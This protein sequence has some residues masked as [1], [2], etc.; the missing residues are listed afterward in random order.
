VAALF[1][2]GGEDRALRGLRPALAVAGV[3]V[4][5]GLVAASAAL[6]T[7]TPSDG[8]TVARLG[9]T[10]SNRYAYW[11]VALDAF[12]DAPLNGH[13][14]GSFGVLWL[15]ERSVPEVVRDAHS[16]W[17]ETAA[18]LGVVG[19][20]LLLMLFGGTAVAALRVP[21]A[22][23]AGPAAALVVW[24]VHSALDWDW[25]LPGGSTL[26]A[27]VLAGLVLAL[28]DELPAR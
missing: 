26:M 8:A 18:E 25:E 2:R 28:R 1:A 6:E 3:I 20:A 13:G 15:R 22:W 14:A 23:V 4:A 5:I 24:V 21:P 17:F 11:G 16:I 7:G 10:D 27:V 19:L 12:A 9:S